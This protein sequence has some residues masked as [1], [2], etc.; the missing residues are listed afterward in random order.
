MED[1][2]KIESPAELAAE[3]LRICAD[4]VVQNAKSAEQLTTRLMSIAQ[5]NKQLQTHLAALKLAAC[6]CGK[7]NRFGMRE[8]GPDCVIHSAG[9][10]RLQ[11]EL[12]GSRN[13]E[14]EETASS[15]VGGKPGKASGKKKKGYCNCRHYEGYEPD[16]SP[17]PGCPKH[18]TNA[19]KNT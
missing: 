6:R 11:Q 9:G 13:A 2:S 18:G 8:V 3:V 5:L 14:Q 7:V 12:Q 19:Q 10:I 4:Y 1:L 16:T 15:L 17:Y